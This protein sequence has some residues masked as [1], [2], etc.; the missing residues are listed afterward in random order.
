MIT[1][2][3]FAVVAAGITLLSATYLTGRHVALAQ[4]QLEMNEQAYKDLDKSDKQLNIVY[5]QL[6]SNWDRKN[7]DEVKTYNKIVAA[8][9]TW[10]AYRDAQGEMTASITA[11]GGS[12][13]PQVRA[14]TQAAL[15]KERIKMIKAQ[16]LAM[17]CR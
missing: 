14:S 10:G 9:R 17:R 2:R 4:T 12:M 13:Y 6:L 8:E 3:R 11:E 7:P 15:T 16:L 5:K 1:L